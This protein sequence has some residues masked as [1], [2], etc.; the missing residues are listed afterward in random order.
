MKARLDRLGSVAAVVAAAAC[1]VCF[2]KLA[3]IGAVFGLGAFSAYEYQLL[4]AAQ[5]LVALA[6][7]GH[8][9]SYRR[10]RNRWLLASALLG[11]SGVFVG[12][13]VAGSELVVY[14]GLAVLL[15]AS[16]ADLWKR[17]RPRRRRVLDSEITCPKCGLKRTETMP[18]D[19]CLFFYQ[20]TGCGAR[21]Q[22][23]PGDCCVFCSYG[24]VKCP[25][26]PAR[27]R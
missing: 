14:A 21:L 12:L 19:A 2:P 5:A 4:V 24:S 11:A 20:C 16:T 23:K 3:L 26:M 25:P 18:I 7:V 6:V 27:R 9:L 10:H 15:A 22:P 13:Y 17:L 8:L 1:P